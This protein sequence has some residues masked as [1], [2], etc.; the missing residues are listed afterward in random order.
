LKDRVSGNVDDGYRDHD[1]GLLVE[2]AG[3]TDFFAEEAE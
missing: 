2:Q 1:A 3:H